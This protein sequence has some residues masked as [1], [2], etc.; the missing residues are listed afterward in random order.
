MNPRTHATDHR[1][2]V[3]LYGKDVGVLEQSRGSYSFEFVSEYWNDPSRL[4]LGLFFEDSR[5]QRVISRS[6]LPLWFENALPEDPLR[7]KLAAVYDISETNGLGLLWALR[8][9]LPGA[10]TLRQAGDNT[11]S[12]KPG[13]ATSQRA[14]KSREASELTPDTPKFSLAGAFLK[15]SLNKTRDRFTLPAHGNQGDHIVKLPDAQHPGLPELEYAT[16][17]FAARCG[18]NVPQ[19]SLVRRDQLD[20]APAGWWPE[21]AESAY[22]IERFDRSPHGPIHMEDFAQVLAKHPVDKYQG[23]YEQIAAVVGQACPEDSFVEFVK[24]LVFSVI[25]GNGDAHIKNFSI[26]LHNNQQYPVLAPAYDIVP[27]VVFDPQDALALKLA[28]SKRFENVR[29]TDF[30]RLARKAGSSVEAGCVA[31]EVVVT[32]AE[33]LEFLVD[34]LGYNRQHQEALQNRV[35]AMA[36]Q[37]S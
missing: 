20:V 5:P 17:R 35:T 32:A 27:T 9:D 10:L 18:I 36:A 25:V 24:Q 4:V 2:I 34:D 11:S 6:G 23:S 30:T 29:L 3:S 19:V 33:H 12:Q 16:M 14:N 28:G 21:G 31:R 8:Q 26:L 37:L 15:M 13:P 7:R 22:C 1:V